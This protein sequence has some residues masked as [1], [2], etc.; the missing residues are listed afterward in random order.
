MANRSC[1]RIGYGVLA[2]CIFRGMKAIGRRY[3]LYFPCA[4]RCASVAPTQ[5]FEASMY[6]CYG[7]R[8]SMALRCVALIIAC[9]SL[10]KEA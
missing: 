9:F 7:C 10:S 1:S 4:H 3:P 8:G 6:K 5:S 2:G